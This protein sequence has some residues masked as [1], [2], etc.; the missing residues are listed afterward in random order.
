MINEVIK[1]LSNELNIRYGV[2]F[3]ACE[4][5]E[6][7]IHK[8]KDEYDLLDELEYLQEKLFNKEVEIGVNTWNKS[9]IKSFFNNLD[10]ID[11]LDLNFTLKTE[12]GL[13]VSPTEYSDVF[14]VNKWHNYL[15]EYIPLG[16]IECDCYNLLEIITESFF[17]CNLVLDGWYNFNLDLRTWISLI[18]EF[19]EI[20]INKKLDKFINQLFTQSNGYI[21]MDYVNKELLLDKD[22]YTEM[23]QYYNIK[24]GE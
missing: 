15:K 9:D 4:L 8:F 2:L 12:E 1:N 16:K 13:I 22:Y 5:L 6:I 11:L 19:K 14:E 23:L 7:D 21:S 18:S 3:N 17:R 24:K 10:E 20:D